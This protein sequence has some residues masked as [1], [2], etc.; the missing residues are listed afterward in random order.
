VEIAPG[1]TGW[2]WDAAERVMVR[3][4]EK[5]AKTRKADKRTSKRKK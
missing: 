1:E 4:G 5:K 3:K 2:R